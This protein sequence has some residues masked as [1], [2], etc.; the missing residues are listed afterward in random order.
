MVR[1]TPGAMEGNMIGLKVH[2]IDIINTNSTSILRCGSLVYNAKPY[3]NLVNSTRTK[4]TE[5]SDNTTNHPTNHSAT[6][7]SG[8]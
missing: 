6:A 2:P 5:P 4:T 3:S 8:R 1:L 7:V